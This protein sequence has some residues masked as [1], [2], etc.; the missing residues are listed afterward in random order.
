MDAEFFVQKVKYLCEKKGVKP[1][2]ACKESGVGASFL[3]DINRGQTPSVAKVQML[4][5]Y[6]G[7]TTSELLGEENKMNRIAELRREHN[8]TQNEL[9]NFLKIA[10]DTLS[11]YENGRRTPDTLTVSKIASR[12]NVSTNYVLGI[13]EGPKAEVEQ[14][15]CLENVTKIHE[16]Y[17]A[18]NTNFFLSLGWKIIHIGVVAETHENGTMSSEVCY[19]LGWFGKS[20][21]AIIPQIS[22]ESERGK[23]YFI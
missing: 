15:F 14:K 6:L 16:T 22:H 19:T 23:R 3:S 9:A 5:T 1:T 18:E 21:D 20:E 13:P 12:F 2:V 4:A 17:D 11:Q 7:V 8:L 10:Q